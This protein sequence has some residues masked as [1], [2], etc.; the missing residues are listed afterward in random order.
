MRL[1]AH[2]GGVTGWRS[3]AAI[4][5]VLA[6]AFLAVFPRTPNRQDVARQYPPS[7]SAA[8]ESGISE[9]AVT[10]DPRVRSAIADSYKLRTHI[11]GGHQAAPE[12]PDSHL[13]T[14]A[15]RRDPASIAEKARIV[16]DSAVSPGGP[17]GSVV[18]TPHNFESRL[19]REVGVEGAEGTT[20]VVRS[21][22]QGTSRTPILTPPALLSVGSMRY[23]PEGYR[24]IV[25]HGASAPGA[26]IDAVEGRVGL[27]ILVL[28]DGS[29]GSVEVA[30]SSGR[31][32]LDAAA[33][34]EVSR[35]KFTP[36]TR[37]GQ[38]IDAWAFVPILFVLR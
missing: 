11:L 8:E 36:A 32:G 37:D 28:A 31:S 1:R 26:A 38:P 4:A 34:R 18:L 27:K 35:W 17:S 15:T 19:G 6:L 7:P 16:G 24:I 25:D 10:L 30:H 20:L 5:G 9:P 33:L 29:V 14:P 21:D 23:P 3:K 2:F 13:I 22:S 12:R